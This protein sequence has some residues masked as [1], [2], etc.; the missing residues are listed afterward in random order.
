M[1]QLGCATS[2][3]RPHPRP[4]IIALFLLALIPLLVAGSS[5]SLLGR[6]DERFYEELVVRPLSGDHVNT[7]FQFTTRWHFGQKENRE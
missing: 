5:K 2:G 6:D 3:P 4:C 7:Y 1:G